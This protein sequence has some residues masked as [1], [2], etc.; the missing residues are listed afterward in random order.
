[1][2]LAETIDHLNGIAPLEYAASWDNVVP[3]D[4]SLEKKVKD[5]PYDRYRSLRIRRSY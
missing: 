4:P 3:I 1:M 2:N 5:T